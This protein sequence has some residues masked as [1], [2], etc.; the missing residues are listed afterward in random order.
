MTACLLCLLFLSP[1][2]ARA[3]DDA[4]TGPMAEK[5]PDDVP[6]LIRALADE[7]MGTRW[8]AALVLGEIGDAAA[9]SALIERVQEDAHP[10]V[11]RRAMTALA[12]LGADAAVPALVARLASEDRLERRDAARALGKLGDREAVAPLIDALE[13]DEGFVRR[14]AARALGQL[15]DKGAVPALETLAQEPGRAYNPQRPLAEHEPSPAARAARF[16]LGELGGE[17]GLAALEKLLGSEQPH[18]RVRAVSTLGALGE[19]G[20]PLLIRALDK[21]GDDDVPVSGSP[22]RQ[23]AIA[24]LEAIGGDAAVAALAQAFE[25]IEPPLSRGDTED[26]RRTARALERLGHPEALPTLRAALEVSEDEDNWDRV[27]RYHR[28]LPRDLRQAIRSLEQ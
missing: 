28:R 23:A 14:D 2:S 7:E 10:R 19:Q 18:V 12:Q 11:R 22:L 4:V 13:D 9:T 17:S 6:V 5:G 21:G 3:T 27:T 1:L 26:M 20:V 25:L 8:N 15:G 16:A 24:A